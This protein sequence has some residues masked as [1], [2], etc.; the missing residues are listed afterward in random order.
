G[1]ESGLDLVR[2][3]ADRTSELHFALTPA[4]LPAGPGPVGTP[5]AG[6]P[7]SAPPT[8]VP[9]P[10]QVRGRV[11]GTGGQPIA[12]ATVTAGAGGAVVASARTNP[13]GEYLL[14]LRAGAYALRA[15]APGYAP[16]SAQA[17]VVARQQVTVDFTLTPL[18]AP[19]AT[20][21]NSP[22]ATS[23]P[24]PPYP[25]PG[26]T[27]T[28]VPD[29]SIAGVVR[30]AATGAPIPNASVRVLAG[31][32]V[33]R[34]LR[35]DSQG[36][37]AVTVPAHAYAVEAAATGYLQAQTQVTVTANQQAT[38]N[39][40][41]TLMPPTAT[42]TPTQPTATPT[43]TQ[44]TATPWPYPTPGPTQ[45]P[46]QNGSVAGVVTSAA[47]G[48]PI[49]GAQVRIL[50]GGEL[51]TTVWTDG[52]GRYSMS[53]YPSVGDSYNIDASAAGYQQA[54]T[55]VVVA[56]NQQSTVNFSLTPL[57]A[58]PATPTATPGPQDLGT[59]T[60]VVRANNGS[61]IAGAEVRAMM[62]G[63]AVNAFTDSQGR[64]TLMAPPGDYRLQAVASGYASVQ[65][66]ALLERGQTVTKDWTLFPISPPTA[67]PTSS[68]ATGALSGVISGSGGPIAGATVRAL[69]GGAAW[70]AVTD[71]QGRY[72]LAVPAGGY[73]VEATAPGFQRAQ[74]QAQVAAGQSATV[75]LTLP[76]GANQ[77]RPAA[78]ALRI[79][80]QPRAF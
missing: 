58:P 61:P 47:T 45:T 3:A 13:Q 15:S 43:P 53:V 1:F 27:Q 64:Y 69:G 8:S 26:P 74:A 48:A 7:V 17:V 66:S 62:A 5:P 11:V 6:T 65:S 49:A 23:R 54:R 44:P 57:N 70:S 72:S 31:G 56:S 24:T 38:V 20:P 28:P 63:V 50:A 36:R 67:T 33:V 4:R 39:F 22:T 12:G 30:S 59:L 34:A 60:G 71:S 29:G 16:A 77:P 18:N 52:Q 75:D 55:Q 46:V 41:L 37:Y 73:G 35:T 42:P 40:A 25:T 9:A 21:A 2:I 10:G 19:T 14:I 78:G 79:A 76:A 51:I 68:P 80:R 32:E